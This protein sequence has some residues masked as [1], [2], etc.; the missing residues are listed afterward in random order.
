M[1]NPVWC[2][3]QREEYGGLS[4]E[5]V[6][7]IYIGLIWAQGKKMAWSSPNPVIGGHC[8]VIHIF[9]ALKFNIWSFIFPRASIA[10]LSYLLI[11][12]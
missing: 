1:E 3:L 6:D 8:H 2:F 12:H 10:L 5:L 9:L 7:D 11:K 4:L